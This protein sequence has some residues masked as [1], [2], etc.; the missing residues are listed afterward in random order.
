MNF[1]GLIVITLWTGV[2]CSLMFF[3]LNYFHLFRVD[4]DTEI[5]GNDIVKHGEPA[6]PVSAYGGDFRHLH[7]H[8][9]LGSGTNKNQDVSTGPLARPF[10]RTAHSFA[11]SALLASLARSAALIHSLAHSR[12]VNN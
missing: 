2:L 9:A 5:V 4:R 1:A 12:K 11:C 7:N 8:S 6:Y 3:L 10:A